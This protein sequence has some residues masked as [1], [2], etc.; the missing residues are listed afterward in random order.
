MTDDDDQ[1]Y[2]DCP[3]CRTELAPTENHRFL[4]CCVCGYSE[5]MPEPEPD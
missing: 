5:P 4:T 1:Q 3:R 2:D